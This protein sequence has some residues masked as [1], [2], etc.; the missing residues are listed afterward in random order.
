MIMSYTRVNWQNAPSTAT[1]VNAENLNTMDKGIADAHSQLAEKADENEVIGRINLKRDKT[2]PIGLNDVDAEMLAAIAG[3]EG[4]S[5][6]LESVPRD[7]SVSPKKTSFVEM[8]KNKWDGTYISGYATSS[9]NEEVFPTDIP[10]TYG[11]LVEI[12][13]G[14]HYSIT[15]YSGG[16]RFRIAA[17]NERPSSV[18]IPSLYYD[19]LS[20]SS[21]TL[22]FTNSVNAKYLYV[23][24]ASDSPTVPDIMVEEGEKTVY[25]PPSYRFR[26]LSPKSIDKKH[27]SDDFN[28]GMV[29]LLN[30]ALKG[31]GLEQTVNWEIGAISVITGN[32]VSLN[33]RARTG[34]IKVQKGAKV[35]FKGPEHIKGV[36]VFQ[37]T[38]SD[39]SFIKN[40]NGYTWFYEVDEDCYIRILS[41]YSD[42]RVIDNL[43]EIEENILIENPEIKIDTNILSA[44]Y[45]NR[46]LINEFEF[47]GIL[48][49]DGSDYGSQ[50]NTRVRTDY[51]WT[52][53]GTEITFNAKEGIP[54]IYVFEYSL[55]DKTFLKNSGGYVDKY[56]VSQDCFVRILSR[57]DNEQV[58]LSPY[59]F[60]DICE[61]H[62]SSPPDRPY[63]F[64]NFSTLYKSAECETVNLNNLSIEDMYSEYDNLMDD[65]PY[66]MQKNLLGYGSNSEG[67]EDYDLPIYEYV[68]SNPQPT[69]DLPD[70]SPTI[71]IITA[72]HGNEKSAAWSTLNFFKQM[73]S[74]WKINDTLSSIKSN[75]TFK[76]IPVANPSG[77][78]RNN[79][80]NARGV[81]LNRNFAYRWHETNDDN[82][83]S[84]PYSELETLIL[85]DWIESNNQAE[86]FIDYHNTSEQYNWSYLVTKSEKSKKAYSSL[87]R[88]LSDVWR[89]DYVG[90]NDNLAYG[91]VAAD[92]YLP[93]AYAESYFEAGIDNSV[94][95]EIAWDFN[96][97]MNTKEVI[98]RGVDLLSNHILT[99]L[100]IYNNG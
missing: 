1:P 53:K 73:L 45:E 16:N 3:G 5:F 41:R 99:V 46:Y 26:S 90:E 48:V 55:N 9:L 17:I 42:E 62:P 76:I 7:Y 68:I 56:V 30:N 8:G 67:E 38:L 58:I 100:N 37:Y 51:I 47:G 35:K 70:Y 21:G 81:D 40:S 74:D 92:R 20:S 22:E 94:L 54:G 59:E 27:L 87:M 13:N 66:V 50:G 86:A 36:Y 39:K 34:F 29:Q 93:Q 33:S 65:N 83:G 95:L 78:N 49:S 6:N 52:R 63:L 77:F 12:E 96:G 15:V 25:E 64:G 71:L 98:E 4:T 61:F 88:R 2:T 23:Y 75:V 43:E 31:N 97:V 24:V 85:R 60:K 32:E 44:I 79:R 91:W 18:A 14:V 72:I 19:E 11:A 82:K 84:A 57:Y 89:R 10:N 80:H 69:M 28:Q